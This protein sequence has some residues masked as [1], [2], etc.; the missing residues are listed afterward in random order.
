MSEAL[1]PAGKSI[2]VINVELDMMC[3]KKRGECV[4]VISRFIQIPEMMIHTILNSAQEIKTRAV[5]LLKHTKVKIKHQRCC[6]GDW[7]GSGVS[8]RG[9]RM[10][11]ARPIK[12][13][14][15]SREGCEG[16]NC[17]SGKMKDSRM[18]VKIT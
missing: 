13:S 2:T 18:L 11:S 6:D 8:R 10:L 7:F 3:C 9:S 17:I 14:P 12:S 1:L 15:H 16:G 5:N 4:V